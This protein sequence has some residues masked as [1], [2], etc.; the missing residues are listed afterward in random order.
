MMYGAGVGC[1]VMM[2]GPT[3]GEVAPVGEAASA[4]TGLAAPRWRVVGVVS[5]VPQLAQIVAQTTNSVTRTMFR[6]GR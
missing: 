4:V 3:V 5:G 2:S 6:V 1:G